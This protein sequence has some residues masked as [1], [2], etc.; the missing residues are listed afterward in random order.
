MADETEIPIVPV[1]SPKKADRTEPAPAPAP[2]LSFQEFVLTAQLSAVRASGLELH[3]RATES[4]APR[5]LSE[6]QAAL[7]HYQAQA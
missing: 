5:L 2:L 4:L 1:K 3:L 7:N 6:W